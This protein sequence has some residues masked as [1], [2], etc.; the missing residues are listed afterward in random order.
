M[1]AQFTSPPYKDNNR[2]NKKSLQEAAD[3]V[4]V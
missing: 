3:F 1:S 4:W 2:R